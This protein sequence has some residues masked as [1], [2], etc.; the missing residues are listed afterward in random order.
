MIAIA[1]PLILAWPAHAQ[2][3]ADVAK[4][5]EEER[6][7]TEKAE[8]VKTYS[9]QDLKD[10]NASPLA[11]KT[12]DQPPAETPK[13]KA[14]AALTKASAPEKEPATKTEAYWRD[15]MKP[16]QSRLKDD[17]QAMARLSSRIADLRKRANAIID[18]NRLDDGRA[19]IYGQAAANP[20]NTELVRL[21][22]DQG[23]LA[24]KIEAD[25]KA[26]ADLE[27]EGRRAGAL[28]GWFR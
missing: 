17:E 24:A 8:P 16:L 7:K 27:E 22:T 1:V 9:N 4:K 11:E 10:P 20:A 28:P 19:T 5:T 3:L 13:E 26:V 2:S 18:T 6:A 23:L 14:P 15:R 12:T 25:K 21:Q